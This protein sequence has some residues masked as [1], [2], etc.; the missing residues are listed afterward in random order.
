MDPNLWLTGAWP[1]IMLVSAALTALISIFLLWLFRRAVLRGMSARA[2]ATETPTPSVGTGAAAAAG[3]QPLGIVT[4]DRRT[5]MAK[6]SEADVNYQSAAR[7]LRQVASVYMMAGLVYAVILSLAWTVMAGGGF[8]P[9]RFLLLVSYYAWPIVLALGLIMAI[10]LGERL[11]VAGVYFAIVFAFTLLSLILVPDLRLGELIFLWLFVNGPG[12]LLL[13]TFLNRRVRAVGPL[14]LAFTVAGVTG[15]ILITDLVR[16]SDRLLRAI[17]SVAVP[18]GLGAIA[19]YVLLLLIGFAILGVV[20]WVLLRWIGRRYQQKRISDQTLI[21]DAMW[22]L[23][24][25]VHPI[26][27]AFEGWAWILVGPVAFVAYKLVVWAGLALLFKPP[28]GQAKSPTLLLLRVFSLARHSERLFDAL[29]KR[30]LRAGSMGMIAGPDLVTTTVEPHE[31]LDFV[32]GRLSRQFV[33]GEADLDRRV[34]QLDTQPDPDG[35]Y[36]VNAFFCR[37]DTWQMTMRRLATRSDAVLMDL[38]SFSPSNQGC[39]YELEQL[40]RLVPLQRVVLVVDDTTHRDFLEHT[41]QTLWQTVSA[42][43]PNQD[44]HAA[45]VRLFEVSSRSSSAEI[46]VLFKVL[47]GAQPQ[48][49]RVAAPVESV[50]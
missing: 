46:H 40:L 29:S 33:Q 28:A 39:L 22:L 42:V 8:L 44:Q 24:A 26:T 41:L 25:V 35:R 50:A 36:R 21:L 11:A 7:S 30:W 5:A 9:V 37:A 31:F 12:T 13:L 4:V 38:R 47:G 45:P 1:F 18:L 14:V 43:S 34:S 6:T 10:G 27:F 32:G 20:G 15:A 49:V 23:F 48:T 2:G 19:V 16:R 17:V 3:I